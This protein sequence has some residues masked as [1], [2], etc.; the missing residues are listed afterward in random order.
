MSTFSYGNHTKKHIGIWLRVATNPDVIE[1][2]KKSKL[3]R[4]YETIERIV[5]S[6]YDPETNQVW[7]QIWCRNFFDTVRQKHR[8]N[9]FHI[10]T[11]INPYW[12]CE[13][14]LGSGINFF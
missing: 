9:V 14:D 5:V 7:L 4:F 11:D 3:K 12:S 13:G 10:K 8:S 6:E 2:V 1:L